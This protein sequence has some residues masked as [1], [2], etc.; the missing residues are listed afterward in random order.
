MPQSVP[1]QLGL[2]RAI[3]ILPL[4]I[5]NRL[6]KQYC[7]RPDGGFHFSRMFLFSRTGQSV[8]GERY[9]PLV[10]RPDYTYLGRFE[11]FLGLNT[12]NNFVYCFLPTQLHVLSVDQG[13][14]VQPPAS[15]VCWI[16]L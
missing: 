11:L 5:Y 2:Y 6:S 1:Y 13:S 9:G 14:Q 16:R 7:I 3:L 10:D 12:K 15:S 4:E 8:T